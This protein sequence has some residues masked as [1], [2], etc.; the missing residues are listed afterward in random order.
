MRIVSSEPVE[1]LG[2]QWFGNGEYVTHPRVVC[3]Q[4]VQGRENVMGQ[5]LEIFAGGIEHKMGQSAGGRCS[6][7]VRRNPYRFDSQK[8]QQA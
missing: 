5:G 8:P 3:G 6:R 1:C 2:P 4:V 7:S